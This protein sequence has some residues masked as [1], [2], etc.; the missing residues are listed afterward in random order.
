M[1]RLLCGLA[2]LGVF[3]GGA[4]GAKAQQSYVYTKFDVPGAFRTFAN[5]IN[6]AGQTVGYYLP[7]FGIPEQGFVYSGGNFTT[8]TQ[9]GS[10]TRTYAYGIN[11]SGQIVGS[12]APANQRFQAFLQSGDSYTTLQVPGSVSSSANAINASGQIVGTYIAASDPFHSHGFQYVDGRYTTLDPR[13][14]VDT[15]L[16]GINSS[17]QILGFYIDAQHLGYNFLLSGG[18]Y[19]I[20]DLPGTL[21]NPAGGAVGINDADQ[22]VG[23]YGDGRTSH[24]FVYS[25]GSLTTLD[26]PGSLETYATGINDAGQ[27]VGWYGDSAGVHG[28]L[29]TPVPEPSTLLL[30]AAATFGLIGWGWWRTKQIA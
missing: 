22:I 9:P 20:L 6:D 1:R 7:D 3:V 17:G 23:R 13:G 5:G 11:D 18:T 21:S 29:A 4:G 19:N 24:G 28:F 2:A 15:F 10:S 8:L 12:S 16:Y 27:I 25:D 30:L 26:P 14:S